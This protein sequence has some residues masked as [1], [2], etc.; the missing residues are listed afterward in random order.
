MHNEEAHNGRKLL[1]RVGKERVIKKSIEFASCRQ[2]KARREGTCVLPG[3]KEA[4][5]KTVHHSQK[6]IF[7][8]LET[9]KILGSL[10]CLA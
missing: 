9:E 2:L 4:D 3:R 8:F 10:L 1:S 6:V 5:L 7:N